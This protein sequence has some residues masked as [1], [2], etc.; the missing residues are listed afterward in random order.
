MLWGALSKLDSTS[1]NLNAI[2]S[3]ENQAAFHSALTDVA[4]IAHTILPR[5]KTASMQVL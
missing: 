5:A 2:L 4:A 1:A 3:N